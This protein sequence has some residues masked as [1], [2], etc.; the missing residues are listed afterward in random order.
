MFLLLFTASLIAVTVSLVPL[1]YTLD[2]ATRS[3][4]QSRH[5]RQLPGQCLLSFKPLNSIFAGWLPSGLG[6][7]LHVDSS[8]SW[9]LAFGISFSHHDKLTKSRSS[10]RTSASILS[11]GMALLFE[12]Q[13]Q[14]G[15]PSVE[16]RHHQP[17]QCA[18]ERKQTMSN[19]I[20]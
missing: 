19:G 8:A 18:A 4:A 3:V 17:C 6:K 14:C 15:M 2:L 11:G 20:I 13:R 16:W 9:A 12:A 10:S 7:G 1:K 5:Q